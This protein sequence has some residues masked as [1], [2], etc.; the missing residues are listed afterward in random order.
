MKYAYWTVLILTSIISIALGGLAAYA[1]W[2]AYGWAYYV[3]ALV[4]TAAHYGV[5]YLLYKGN[6]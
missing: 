6:K 4:V 5:L 2:L 3:A 1:T